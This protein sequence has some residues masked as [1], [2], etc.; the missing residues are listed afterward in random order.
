MFS[1]SS[2]VSVGTTVL[3]A[4]GASSWTG[5]T[6][7][8]GQLWFSF[9]NCHATNTVYL[10]RVAAGTA[11]SGAVSSADYGLKLAAGE[12][13]LYRVDDL[14]DIVLVASGASTPV[15]LE[16]WADVGVP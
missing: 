10:A 16:V 4:A 2:T 13:K 15:R 9:T 8:A 7:K 6:T 5:A 11:T 3:R 14:C 12:T 1:L